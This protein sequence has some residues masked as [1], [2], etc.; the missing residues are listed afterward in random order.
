[1]LFNQLLTEVT[2]EAEL[3]AKKII[4]ENRNNKKE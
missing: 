1:M 2:D 3:E 4:S